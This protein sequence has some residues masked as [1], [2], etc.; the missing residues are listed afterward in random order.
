MSL[1]LLRFHAAS[2]MRSRRQAG[3]VRIRAEFDRIEPPSLVSFMATTPESGA[4]LSLMNA[5]LS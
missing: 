1:I 4:V 3:I 5:E 2:A